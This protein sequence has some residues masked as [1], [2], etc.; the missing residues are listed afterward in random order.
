MLR[1]VWPVDVVAAKEV[2]FEAKIESKEDVFDTE[3]TR[4]AKLVDGVRGAFFGDVWSKDESDRL[5][6]PLE[7]TKYRQVCP[8]Q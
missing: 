8:Y 7:S 6:L 3:G 5:F 4:L 1:E 2:F